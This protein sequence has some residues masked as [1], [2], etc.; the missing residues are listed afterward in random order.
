MTYLRFHFFFNLPL[1]LIFGFWPHQPL[2][3][4]EVLLPGLFLLLVVMLFTSPWDNFAVKQR[5]WDFP[6][7]RL[8]GRIGFLP[9]EE[10]AFF[11]IQSLQVMGLIG[12]L[13]LGMGPR[14]SLSDVN[15]TQIGT[16]F[17]TVAVL[18]L[19][20]VVGISLGGRIW[21]TSRFHYAWH[22]LYWFLPLILLQWAFAWPILLPRLDWI[23]TATL[24]IG[25]W[26]S[27]ADWIAVRQGIWFFDEAQITG[28]K[29]GRI[30]PWEEIAFFYITSLLVSQS[31]LILL[32]ETIR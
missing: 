6:D 17:P 10:Y 12:I 13:A 31:F 5:I 30:L 26:L 16:W 8:L 2:W 29:I 23:V 1:L 3:R 21:K 7:E 28:W 22:L 20:L 32:P 9:V 25:T 19:W 15:F 4:A 14:E 24:A 27:F 11:L 18:L